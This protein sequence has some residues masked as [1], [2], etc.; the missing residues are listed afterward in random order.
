[1]SN[2]SK[3]QPVLDNGGLWIMKASEMEIAINLDGRRPALS[4]QMS[5]IAQVAERLTK[6]C[7]GKP[8][9]AIL[10]LLGAAAK[11]MQTNSPAS[12]DD[13]R[14]ALQAVLAHAVTLADDFFD[15]A[16]ERR[17]Q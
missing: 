5:L 12:M 9:D 1:M 17:I 13:R 7:G 8:T 14:D 2:L 15:S 6:E 3:G 16:A 11:L 4:E 10:T